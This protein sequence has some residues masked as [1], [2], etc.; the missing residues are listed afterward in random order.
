M[1]YKNNDEFENESSGLIVF[2]TLLAVAVSLLGIIVC[3]E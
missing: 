1:N 2:I 3:M